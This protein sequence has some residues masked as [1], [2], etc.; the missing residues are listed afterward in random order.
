MNYRYGTFDP[1]TI[2]KLMSSLRLC[3]YESEY[4]YNGKIGLLEIK[5]Q[6]RVLAQT[7]DNS[8]DESILFKEY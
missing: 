6:Q 4:Q 2:I 7:E 8:F 1:V 3:A 5:R